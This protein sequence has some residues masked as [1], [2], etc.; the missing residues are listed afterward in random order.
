MVWKPL[1]GTERA[2]PLSDSL[3]GLANRLGLPP[4]KATK[5]VFAQWSDVVG[6]QIA[7]HAKPVAVVRGTLQVVVDDQRWLTQLKWMAPKVVER[8]NEAMGEPLI[9]ALEARLEHS[10]VPD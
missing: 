9:A 1:R 5:V 10:G 4:T 7:E 6:R 3:E 8:L 2:T